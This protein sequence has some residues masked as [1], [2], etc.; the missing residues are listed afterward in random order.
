MPTKKNKY[1]LTD[2]ELEY[3]RRTLGR[4]PSTFENWM[5]YNLWHDYYRT[6]PYQDI[7][8]RAGSTQDEVPL[9]D[10]SPVNEGTNVRVVISKSFTE[11]TAAKELYTIIMRLLINR[12]QPLA[13]VIS[14]SIL[15][16]TDI[17]KTK[18]LNNLNKIG[19]S[20]GITIFSGNPDLT[21]AKNSVP[22]G[23]LMLTGQPVATVT[24]ELSHSKG[25]FAAVFPKVSAKSIA[26]QKKI[27]SAIM[28]ITT[29]SWII[30]MTESSSRI[31]MK[32]IVR[33]LKSNQIGIE[34]KAS[35]LDPESATG[36]KKGLVPLFFLQFQDG[37]QIE[38]ETILSQYDLSSVEMG[39]IKAELGIRILENSSQIC[40]IPATLFDPD[41]ELTE[42]YSS[43]LPP[44]S[45]EKVIA[46]SFDPKPQANYNSDLIKIMNHL[47]SVKSYC[48]KID[49]GKESGALFMELGQN[50]RL[51]LLNPNLAGSFL[52]AE[53]NR[54]MAC[55]G[56]RSIQVN[57]NIAAGQSGKQEQ[58]L[59]FSEF[60][61][62]ITAAAL[63]L[64]LPLDNI[65]YFQDNALDSSP[66]IGV[67]GTS[68]K[69][70]ED[71]NFNFK[72]AGDFITI[73]GSLRGELGG[74]EYQYRLFGTTPGKLPVIDFNMERRLCE[75]IVLG[76]NE[77]Y[78]NSA[79]SIGAGGLAGA[80]A[81]S[82]RR[83]APELGARIHLSRKLLP[84]E[85]LFGETQGLVLITLDEND[86]MEFERICMNVGVPSTTIG[87]VTDNSR[88]T[89]NELI[90]IEVENLR[91]LN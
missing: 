41:F 32:D 31:W 66:R 42:E 10:N 84:A 26:A 28:D 39:L 13:G 69:P 58:M 25:V 44:D 76:I 22:T 82:L 34:L 9:V 52:V 57:A 8:N 60:A 70:L 49:L 14:G 59:R 87:R 77:K 74:S 71:F 11:K 27:V 90:D 72:T 38:L 56:A 65:D 50:A 88:Y 35:V 51:S 89:F 18:L 1:S 53:A 62:G 6:H 79:Y 48:Q 30:S 67:I 85:L 29:R 36:F 4:I 2:S 23:S 73:L 61:K 78:I 40:T 81:A 5:I 43:I 86:L 54:K 21:V 45:V 75:A 33:L 80:I 24:G 64:Q 12:I 91:R 83:A 46:E 19:K 15:N 55:I 17:S 68:L 3:L 16:T 63:K 47:P 37:F 20:I 7:I